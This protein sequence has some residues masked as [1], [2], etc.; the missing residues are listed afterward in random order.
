MAFFEVRVF[1]SNAKRCSTKSLQGC[2]TNNEKEKKRQYNTR[3]LQVENRSF[4]PLVF[5]ING[6]MSWEASKCYS[7]IAEMLCEKHDEHHLL[8]MFWMRR[9]PSFSLMRSIIMCIRGSKTF[10]SSKE[11]QCTSEAGSYSET[12]C[13]IQEAKSK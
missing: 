3:V 5:N 10:K 6:R 12:S 4:S 8:T 2:F 7:R 13:V 1:D 11:K 9:K